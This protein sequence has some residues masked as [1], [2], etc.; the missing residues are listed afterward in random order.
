MLYG[1]RVV[2]L[3]PDGRYL[4]VSQ[5]G[6]SEQAAS[7]VQVIDLS[8]SG[9]LVA[10]ASYDGEVMSWLGSKRL[11]SWR[12]DSSALLLDVE[13]GWSA[14]LGA[15]SQ[16]VSGVIPLGRD[17]SRALVGVERKGTRDM[18]LVEVGP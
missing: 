10:S 16:E 13:A 15:A 8:E 9:K 11:I 4:A 6:G 17:G 14:P 7:R 3:S 1:R 5:R 12:G 18:W 2:S